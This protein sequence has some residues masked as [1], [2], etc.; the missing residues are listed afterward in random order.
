[1]IWVSPF[2]KTLVIWVSPVTLTLTQIAKVIS[3][4]DAHITET[5]TTASSEAT[6]RMGRKQR[7]LNKTTDYSG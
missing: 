6:R 3:E 7:S 1:M 2:P 4:G 5:G